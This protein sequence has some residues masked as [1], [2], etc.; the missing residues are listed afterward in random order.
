MSRLK[1]AVIGAGFFGRLH[2]L[3]HADLPDAELVAVCD[4]DPQRAAEV[5]A[6]CGTAPVSDFRELLSK[7]D[8]VSI[9]APTS[10]H[11]QLAAA[12]L[13]AGCH[14]LVEKPITETP[15]Q[16][17]EL[18]GLARANGLVL[19]VGHLLR[20]SPAMM[21]LQDV[22]DRPMFIECQRIAP[23]KMRGTDI[24]VVLDMMIHDIDLVLDIVKE[25]IE[26]IDAIGV[27]VISN[28]EDI[29]NARIRFTSGCVA[30]VTASRVSAKTERKLRLFQHDA[31]VRIDMHD[32]KVQVIR[33][34]EGNATGG[35][36]AFTGEEREFEAGDPLRSQ[37]ESFL[38]TVK[39]GGEPLVSGEDGLRALECA[40]AI[41]EK[42]RAW[43][44]RVGA[45]KM[46]SGAKP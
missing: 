32:N 27:P 17:R 9:A 41:N 4:N 1:T 33:K 24:N 18:I 22:I 35:M 40:I 12:F 45:D 10:E 36:P 39:A 28:E 42:L 13:E 11:H 20:F 8:A 31:Y 25:P 44:D 46:G 16:A 23:F 26:E 43:A 15:E 2:A 5:A 38:A 14:V 29:A 3:K 6:E 19:Q 7:V 21:G 34:T 37:I 30:T